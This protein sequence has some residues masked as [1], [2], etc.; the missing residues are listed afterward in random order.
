M[1][2]D[3]FTCPALVLNRYPSIERLYFPFHRVPNSRQITAE[4]H[5]DLIPVR[6][7]D[8]KQ[9]AAFGRGIDDRRFERRMQYRLGH[10]V[11]CSQ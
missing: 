2:N 1:F 3:E 5:N 4:P 8:E 6:P 11:Y 9:I 7:G 10:R